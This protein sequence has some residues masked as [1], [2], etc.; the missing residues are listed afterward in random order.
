M[1]VSE[2]GTKFVAPKITHGKSRLNKQAIA[3][4]TAQVIPILVS[5]HTASDYL[6]PILILA[7]YFMTLWMNE[8]QITIGRILY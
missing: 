4:L 8:R 1:D 3:A 6:R 7:T 5:S 2:A